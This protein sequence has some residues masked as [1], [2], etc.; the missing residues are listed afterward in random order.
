MHE[1]V[2]LDRCVELLSPAIT[3]AAAAG[4]RPVFV[5]ATLGL[6]GHTEA[7]LLAHGDL[8][9]VGIDT[10][11]SALKRAAARLQPLGDPVDASTTFDQ[12]D[13][14]LDSLGLEQVDAVLFDLGVSGMQLDE[15][16]VVSPTPTTLRSTCGWTPPA[17]RQ[18]RTCWPPTMPTASHGCCTSTATSDTPDGSRLRWCEF[19]RRNRCEPRPT[20]SRCCSARS[21]TI[22][23]DGRSSGQAHVSGLAGGSQ[24]RVGAD[25]AGAAGS[26][27]ASGSRRTVGRDVV[28]VTRDRIVK[29]TFASATTASVPPGLPVIPRDARPRFRLLTR[30]QS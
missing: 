23:A 14:A 6:G 19:A 13:E 8:T 11:P 12:F 2:M 4:R 15:A 10:D 29:R 1:P 20:S 9:A 28:P 24:R 22:A 25:P 26:D 16:G 7:M 21:P 17:A 3:A 30:A 18:P 5:D 27:G